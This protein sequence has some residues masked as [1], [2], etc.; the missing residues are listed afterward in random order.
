MD[1]I[2][3]KKKDLRKEYQILVNEILPSLNDCQYCNQLKCKYCSQ[4]SVNCNKCKRDRCFKCHR[5]NKSKDILIN[6]GDF[7]VSNYVQDFL[8][9]YFKMSDLSNY[10]LKID[11]NPIVKEKDPT[12][13]VKF[14]NKKLE[15]LTRKKEENRIFY[16]KS[17][18]YRHYCKLI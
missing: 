10:F 14:D 3:G 17:K 2:F 1:P 13:V 7:F 12:E 6:C 9:D 15:S 16:F 18:K 4:F 11:I 8:H 5:F